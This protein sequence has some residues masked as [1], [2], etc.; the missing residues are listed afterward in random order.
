MKLRSHLHLILLGLMLVATS[1]KHYSTVREKRPGYRSDTPAGELIKHA[2]R[3]SDKQPEVQIGKYL[4]AASVAGESL[5]KNPEDRQA[6]TDYNYAAGRIFEVIHEAK[7]Q[8]WKKPVSCPGA[9]GNWSFSMT[10]DGKPE[11]DPSHFRIL[12]ADRYT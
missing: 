2:L 5:K 1:C 8:P 12:P 10:T 9:D 6:R 4:D 3:H 11:H 7:L